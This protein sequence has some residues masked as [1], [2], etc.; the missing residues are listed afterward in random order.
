[1]VVDC[2]GRL[3]S[4]PSLYVRAGL[5][6]PPLDRG[7]LIGVEKGQL[8][9]QPAQADGCC[10]ELNNNLVGLLDIAAPAVN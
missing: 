8:I 10:F 4:H 7:Q 6:F 3:G 5:R 2:L 1:M 9:H